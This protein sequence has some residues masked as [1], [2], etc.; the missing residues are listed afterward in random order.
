MAKARFIPKILTSNAKSTIKTIIK[1]TDNLLA[2]Y[3]KNGVPEK[4]REKSD[5]ILQYF[6][7]LIENTDFKEKI[8]DQHNDEYSN[9]WKLSKVMTSD[10]HLHNDIKTLKSKTDK[11]LTYLQVLKNSKSKDLVTKDFKDNLLAMD[12]EVFQKISS[13][14]NR[15]AHRCDGEIESVGGS[16][17]FDVPENETP[18]KKQRLID[19]YK[20]DFSTDL[21]KAYKD[22]KNDVTYSCNIK[23]ILKNIDENKYNKDLYAEKDINV[24]KILSLIK[25]YYPNQ[26]VDE[27]FLRKYT[28]CMDLEES[29]VDFFEIKNQ[30]IKELLIYQDRAKELNKEQGED[31][32][33]EQNIITFV[34]P[35]VTKTKDGKPTCR[36]VSMNK[37]EYDTYIRFNN[38]YSFSTKHIKMYAKKHNISDYEAERYM[39]DAVSGDKL[40]VTERKAL[41]AKCAV[42][43][44]HI[45]VDE[46]DTFVN[47]HGIKNLNKDYPPLVECFAFSGS[48]LYD[49]TPSTEKEKVLSSVLARQEKICQE[50]MEEYTKKYV[51][52]EEQF[53][54]KNSIKDHVLAKVNERRI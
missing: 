44:Y 13:W 41:M 12:D 38:S 47:D 34:V 53:N 22:F 27:E 6:Y 28:Y 40:T 20:R 43:S 17:T 25:K 15:F 37:K 33:E 48:T 35:D 8:I 23:E 42:N 52:P 10:K 31:L 50:N 32:Y 24:Q 1:S 14:A 19:G 49:I 21:F 36:V 5:T 9:D 30:A 26:I 39:T 7:Y 3:D 46:L 4:I 2:H 16:L 54:K 29:C 51:E 11:K 18:A 45:P